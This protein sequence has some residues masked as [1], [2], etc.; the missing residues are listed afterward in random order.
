VDSLSTGIVWMSV[1]T[2]LVLLVKEQARRLSDFNHM[3]AKQRESVAEDIYDVCHDKDC[4]AYYEK[5][6]E[7]IPDNLVYFALAETRQRLE[8]SG[9]AQSAHALFTETMDRI[10]SEYGCRLEA[11]AVA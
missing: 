5:I 1:A 6:A 2:A 10:A 4:V 11:R 3:Q 7:G 8:E 9:G